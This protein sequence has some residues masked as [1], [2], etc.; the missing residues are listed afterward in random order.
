MAPK[1]PVVSRLKVAIPPPQYQSLAMF[2]SV[3]GI[4]PNMEHVVG[5][6]ADTGVED[7]SRLAKEWSMS[8][9]GTVWNFKLHEGIPFQLSETPGRLTRPAP[10]LG[11]HTDYVLQELLG[12]RGILGVVQD[13]AEEG[14]GK[15]VDE[16][17]DHVHVQLLQSFDELALGGFVCFHSNSS[18]ARILARK[19]PL[20][21]YSRIPQGSE[22]PK[23]ANCLGALAFATILT[24]LGFSSFLPF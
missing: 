1:I 6:D 23:P 16:P 22:K 7:A 2:D 21:N 3:E 14:T 8:S 4:L 19:I 13:N 10:L 11:E 18:A 15:S 12:I 9:D 24:W 5:V 20:T 17:V